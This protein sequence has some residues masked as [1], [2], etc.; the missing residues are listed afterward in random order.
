MN[1]GEIRTRGRMELGIARQG[2]ATNMERD[3]Y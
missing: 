1:K 3:D 2:K